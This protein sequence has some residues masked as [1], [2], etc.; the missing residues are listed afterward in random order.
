MMQPGSAQDPTEKQWSGEKDQGGSD[1]VASFE[2][3]TINSV[4]SSCRFQ[5]RPQ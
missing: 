4:L 2:T 3:Y 1:F 5:A